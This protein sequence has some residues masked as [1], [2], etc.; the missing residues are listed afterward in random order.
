MLHQHIITNISKLRKNRQ[1]SG[2]D[3]A[4]RK[5]FTSPDKPTDSSTPTTPSTESGPSTRVQPTRNTSKK[6]SWAPATENKANPKKPK[7]ILKESPY[8]TPTTST[9][10]SKK[11]EKFTDLQ[12]SNVSSSTR[13]TRKRAREVAKTP[14]ERT[15]PA[16]ARKSSTKKRIKTTDNVKELLEDDRVYVFITTPALICYPENARREGSGLMIWMRRQMQLK[17]RMQWW[18][19]Y[20]QQAKR[21]T[22]TKERKRVCWH[23]KRNSS[24]IAT[25]NMFLQNILSLVMKMTF[26]SY[27]R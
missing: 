22:T 4:K 17:L 2:D 23:S 18:P 25:T 1:D 8:Q 3:K 11:S 15:K 5:L 7:P 10:K 12:N 24:A 13:I 27:L 16:T 26:P 20:H 21:K 14:T 6:V 9:T 19:I